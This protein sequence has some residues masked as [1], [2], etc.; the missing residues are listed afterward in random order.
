LEVGVYGIG[1]QD[2]EA[3]FGILE[4]FTVS[5]GNESI[6]SLERQFLL[7]ADHAFAEAR[8]RALEADR[9]VLE[10]VGGAIYR[11]FA[12]GA[13]EFIKH[14]E[15]PTQYPRGAKFKLN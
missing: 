12:N 14:I 2:L 11:V 6:E 13:R 7:Q 3:M 1:P 8:R 15:P 10:A 4:N 9:S 5:P